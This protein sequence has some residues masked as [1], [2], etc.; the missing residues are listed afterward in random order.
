MADSKP[1]TSKSKVVS[2]TKNSTMTGDANANQNQNPPA[3]A[4][5]NPLTGGLDLSALIQAIKEN[6]SARSNAGAAPKVSTLLT[7]FKEF[8]LGQHGHSKQ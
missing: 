7:P 5:G 1:H 3:G 4:N 6:T 2:P 8:Y